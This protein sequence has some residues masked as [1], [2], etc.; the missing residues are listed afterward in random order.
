MPLPDLPALGLGGGTGIAG[1]SRQR[2]AAP[3]PT[4]GTPCD[5]H[6]PSCPTCTWF[7]LAAVLTV[8]FGTPG[9]HAP[10]G[11][12]PP[13]AASAGP[14][15]A[16][17]GNWPN[18]STPG[19]G[20]HIHG[21]RRL[22]TRFSIAPTPA[23]VLAG[24]PPAR[25]GAGSILDDCTH[26]FRRHISSRTDLRFLHIP[27]DMAHALI[28]DI[29]FYQIKRPGHCNAPF[30]LDGGDRPTF[31]ARVS[32]IDQDGRVWP[33]LY[34]TYVTGKQYHRRLTAGWCLFAAHHMLA[35]G[36]AVD[37]WRRTGD[38]RVDALVVRVQV[39]RGMPT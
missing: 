13:P 26:T 20:R 38:K 9:P 7:V 31:V 29:M 10:H 19:A 37:F 12:L 4:Q 39:V 22:W 35:A 15:N 14:G 33:L 8:A 30:R 11:A 24:T 23:G 3:H 21:V 18:S 2:F 36:D 32:A 34:R 16:R 27:R 5:G 6:A 1:R 25:T 28:P 17:P